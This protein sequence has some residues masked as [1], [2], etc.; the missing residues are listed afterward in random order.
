MQREI[1]AAE[2]EHKARVEAIKKQH[3]IHMADLAKKMEANTDK[4]KK[5]KVSYEKQNLSMEMAINKAKE[6]GEATT[7]PI[8][9]PNT[10]T[11]AKT[12]K[13]TP[14]QQLQPGTFVTADQVNK[15]EV[16]S[17]MLLNPRLA[18]I[19]QV[20][21]AALTTFFLEHLN[22]LANAGKSGMANGDAESL[23]VRVEEGDEG[24]DMKDREWAEELQKARGD[25]EEAAFKTLAADLNNDVLAITNGGSS[26]T[27][28]E[29]KSKG[30]EGRS[31]SPKQ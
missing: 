14:I 24:K 15:E 31:R 27:K 11:T 17:K 28:I 8:A 20:Q 5:Y 10:T 22:A 19:S 26:G 25:A 6:I 30:R 18:G 4:L 9:P 21:A 12:V 3:T 13:P 29:R 7:T 2:D 1:K 23:P 16:C